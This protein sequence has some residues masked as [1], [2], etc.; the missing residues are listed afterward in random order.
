M[1]HVRDFFDRGEV[2]AVWR[3]ANGGDLY[4]LMMLSREGGTTLGRPANR[5]WRC[6]IWRWKQASDGRL[7][8]AGRGYLF[9]GISEQG[10]P[11]PR[12]VL[13]GELGTVAAGSAVAVSWAGE[14]DHAGEQP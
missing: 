9:R 6:G 5:P 2:L 4:S 14:A 11:P 13:S 8:V 12:V 3:A 7:M 10:T 1:Q